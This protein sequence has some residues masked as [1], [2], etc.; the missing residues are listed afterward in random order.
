MLC[1]GRLEKG[2][3]TIPFVFPDTVVRVKDVPAEICASC[4]EPF[5]D[6][7]V[8]DRLTGLLNQARG[9]GAEVLIISYMDA[10]SVSAP[11]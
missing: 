9:M 4:Q 1:G 2:T 6:G 11:A 7:E 10:Q 5:T 8:T 3:A